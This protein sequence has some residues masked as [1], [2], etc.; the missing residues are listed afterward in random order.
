MNKIFVRKEQIEYLIK[1]YPG[2]EKI[3]LEK[4]EYYTKS[5]N[6]DLEFAKRTNYKIYLNEIKDSI[7]WEYPEKGKD[8]PKIIEP[9]DIPEEK[10]EYIKLKKNLFTFF[11]R[12]TNFLDVVERFHLQNP[13]YYDSFKNWWMWRKEEFRWERIDETDLMNAIDELTSLPHTD[14]S[15]KGKLLEAFKRV[16]RKRK[17]LEPEK[18]WIQFKD[19]IIDIKTKERFPASSKYFIFNPIPWNIGKTDK[20]P[21]IDNLLH[22]W[23]FKENYQNDDY[24]RTLKEIIA[25]CFLADMPIHRIF[26]F[27][28]EGLN[29]KG[30]FLRLIENFIGDHNKTSTEIEFLTQSNFESSKLFRKLICTVGEIDK[31][32]FKR[33]KTIKAL[34]GDDLIRAEYKGK[35]SFDFHN[36]AKILISTNHLPETKDKAKGFYRRW[37]IVDFP[38]EFSEKKNILDE[39]PKVEYENFC[40]QAI[41]ILNNLIINGEFTNDGTIQD[42]TKRYEKFSND[43]NHYISEFYIKDSESSIEFSEFSQDYNDYLISEGKKKK[44]K[45]EIG[46]LIENAGFEKKIKK[47]N[48]N[49]FTTTKMFINGLKS[50]FG[51][52]SV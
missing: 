23:T 1:T 27:I 32:V 45:V 13:F 48:Q 15:I 11:N 3:I 47:I 10:R 30:T 24:V 16:G 4:I 39:I 42:R 21:V 5:F 18:T 46:R 40:N 9:K 38:N 25:Y 41:S 29:G 12:E 35:D 17:P 2:A 44:S 26:C 8:L 52:L 43:V 37:T 50:K 49:N 7:Y 6:E 51:G 36:Y 34:S 28:G 19:T 20:T 14:Q 31:G 33:T 22:S